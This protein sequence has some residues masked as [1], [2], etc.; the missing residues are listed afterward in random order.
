MPR[1]ADLDH[2]VDVGTAAEAAVGEDALEPVERAEDLLARRRVGRRD[3]AEARREIGRDQRVLGRVVVV[4]RSLADAGL[5]RHGV[6]AHGADALRIEQLV[7][8]GEDALGWG[9]VEVHRSV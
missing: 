1:V 5:G 3:L 7:G 8:C 2:R 6:D 4:Q 9:A